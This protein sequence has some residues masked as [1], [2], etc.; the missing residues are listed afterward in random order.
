MNTFFNRLA[1]L[2][3]ERINRE[4]KAAL[5]PVAPYLRKLSLGMLVIVLSFGLW[6][7]GLLFL[8]ISLFVYLGGLDAY[9]HPALWTSLISFLLGLLTVMGGLKLLRRPR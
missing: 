9:F 4:I 6:L 2:F 5:S 7:L 8:L 1:A 3:G